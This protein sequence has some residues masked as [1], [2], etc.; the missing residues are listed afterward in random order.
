MLEYCDVCLQTNW[1]SSLKQT[2][3]NST[4]IFYSNC[5][6]RRHLSSCVTLRI[7]MN[8]PDRKCE[9]SC[10]LG[11]SVL[12]L[13][14]EGTIRPGNWPRG[15]WWW[16]RVEECGWPSHPL[17]P[18]DQWALGKHHSSHAALLCARSREQDETKRRIACST[19]FGTFNANTTPPTHR[20]RRRSPFLIFARIK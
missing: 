19:T 2:A 14:A 1:K 7:L 20:R 18:G 11:Q 15:L 10:D 9:K 12:W 16:E 4:Q 13:Q 3:S 5:N 6:A 17:S 8:A